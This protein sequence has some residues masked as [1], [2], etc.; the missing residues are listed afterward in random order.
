[1]YCNAAAFENFSPWHPVCFTRVLPIQPADPV[2]DDPLLLA[3]EAAYLANP[4]IAN[5]LAVVEAFGRCGLLSQQDAANL[6]PALDFFGADFFELIGEV[7]ANAG[8]F[9]CALRWYREYIAFLEMQTPGTR[10]DRE[11]VFADVGYCLY[12]LGLF[13]EAITW[14][15]SCVG[16]DLLELTVGAALTDYQ[17]QLF[18]GRLLA[19]ERAANRA[20]YT[21]STTQDMEATRQYS[22]QLKTAFR[23]ATPFQEVY[24]YWMSAD[25]PVPSQPAEGYPFKYE[26]EN[27][28]LPRHKMNLLFATVALADYLAGFGNTAEAGRLLQEAALLEPQA[29]FVQ[30]RLRADA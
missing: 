24:I 16:P 23:K 22:D 8:M 21:A 5:R 15:K 10:S 18:G 3:S 14:T 28:C 4:N 20:R 1:M 11:D 13:A 7:Y 17:A 6:K 30:D 29:D 26:V 12:S 19:T 27:G 2:I 25:A 9:V